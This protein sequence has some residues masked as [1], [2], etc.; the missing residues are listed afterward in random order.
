[1]QVAGYAPSD[2]QLV[3]APAS[4]DDE[5]LCREVQLHD[6]HNNVLEV[7]VT[8]EVGGGCV[9]MLALHAAY[10]VVNNTGLPIAIRELGASHG[11]S[12]DEASVV[13]EVVCENQRRP[14]A[15]NGFT[16][17]G[18]LPFSDAR[19]QRRVSSC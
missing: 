18:S 11:F 2:R 19:M 6:K 9:H 7:R 5:V 3:A 8:Y 10:W 1:M 12:G 4:Y 13:R 16:S 17:D 15:L 14:T